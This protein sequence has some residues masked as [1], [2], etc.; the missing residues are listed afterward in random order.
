MNKKLIH[1]CF[2]KQ[3]INLGFVASSFVLAMYLNLPL[4]SAIIFSLVIYFW[5]SDL[6][7]EFYRNI[8]VVF[9]IISAIALA[10]GEQ[11]IS[12]KLAVISFVSLVIL[13]V[14]LL[15][16]TRNDNH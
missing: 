14:L 6:G 12:E 5:L 10:I 2:S 1:Y 13:L 11:S 8:A 4:E 15:I 7:E 9:A 3:T 16:N